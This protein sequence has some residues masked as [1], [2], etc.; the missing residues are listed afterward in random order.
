VK[1][2]SGCRTPVF[3]K[4]ALLPYLTIGL[5][6]TKTCTLH[7]DAGSNADK[8]NLSR[9]AGITLHVNMDNTLLFSL[10][11]ELERLSV[12]S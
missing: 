7:K 6:A 12:F 3:N 11:F 8:I 1:E 9:D 10:L 2:K 5:H 4:A